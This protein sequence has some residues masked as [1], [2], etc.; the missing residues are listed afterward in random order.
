MISGAAIGIGAGAVVTGSGLGAGGGY[1]PIAALGSDLLGY[2]EAR[3][4]DSMTLNAE[5]VS[6]WR[7]LKTGFALQQATGA[8]Q[9]GY[10][11]NSFNGDAGVAF[12]GVDDNLSG[13]AHPY[14][15]GATACEIWALFSQTALPA[16][17]TQ[18][19]VVGLGGGGASQ[20]SISRQVVSAANRGR[21]QVGD[22]ATTVGASVTAVDLSSR[23]V[24]RHEIGAAGFTISIDGQAMGPTAVVPATLNTRFRL[25]AFIN[26]SASNFHSGQIAAVLITNPLATDKA[27]ALSA[28]L[29]DRRKL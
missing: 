6:E 28:W 2:F 3:R 10:S 4:P 16:D 27:A 5:A 20:R 12:D 1:D 18:R 21:G 7:C 9:P 11:A 29:M 23:H 13:N 17:T 24:A 15:V 14:P 19:Y 26:T 22:G 8:A 25:G